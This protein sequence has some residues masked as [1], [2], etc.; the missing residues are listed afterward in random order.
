MDGVSDCR[1]WVRVANKEHIQDTDTGTDT[2]TRATAKYWLY[3][4]RGYPTRKDPIQLP[5]TIA[6]YAQTVLCQQNLLT[7]TCY[8]I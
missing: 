3:F 2:A 4:L 1:D 6:K 8:F 5:R 7:D